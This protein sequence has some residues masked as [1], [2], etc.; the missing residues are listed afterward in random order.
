MYPVQGMSKQASEQA[1]KPEMESDN[2]GRWARRRKSRPSGNEKAA[3]EA[4]ERGSAGGW[5]PA[6][7]MGT[8]HLYSFAGICI[9]PVQ[10]PPGR[11]VQIPPAYPQSDNKS[12]M[13]LL[14]AL[15]RAHY[16]SGEGGGSAGATLLTV[17]EYVT[18]GHHRPKQGQENKVK[19]KQETEGTSQRSSLKEK[20]AKKAKR[21]HPHKR[22]QGS[23]NNRGHGRQT[24]SHSAGAGG[25]GGG[26]EGGGGDDDEQRAKGK[27]GSSP[28]HQASSHR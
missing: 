17:L 14:I 19:R 15:L 7:R 3:R 26:G 23:I 24:A 6:Y 8:I 28:W 11:T 22:R 18:P 9:H 4:R 25:G 2:E 1:S 12:L 27:G 21:G 13:A 20:K 16:N 5:L 10:F